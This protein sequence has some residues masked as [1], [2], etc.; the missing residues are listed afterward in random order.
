MSTKKFKVSDIPVE[1]F[2]LMFSDKG[3][4][5]RPTREF[6]I[7][8][9]INRGS[10]GSK[11]SWLKYGRDLF[12]YFRFLEAHNFKWTQTER[13]PSLLSTYRDWSI[14]HFS[15]KASTINNRLTIIIRFYNYAFRERWIEVLPFGIERVKVNKR[16]HFLIHADY[17]NDVMKA[18]VKLK[19]HDSIIRILNYDQQVTLLKALKNETHKCWTLLALA[20]GLRREELNT[21]PLKYI[22]NP[23][24]DPNQN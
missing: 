2:P 15:L 21:L 13:N 12:D 1:G 3:K 5:H 19:T 4:P 10:V 7:Y 8:H 20:T 24:K 11:S 18:D 17:H 23:A 6:M 22:I 9:C 14:E 16:E